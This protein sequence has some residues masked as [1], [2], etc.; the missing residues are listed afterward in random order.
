MLVFLKAFSVIFAAE[1]GDK[2][3]FL[4]IAMASKYRMRDIIIGSAGAICLLNFLA[5]ALGTLLGGLFSS[6]VV[7]I[8]SGI[9]FLCFAYSSFSESSSDGEEHAASLSK[10]AVSAVIVTFFV[11]EFGDKTQ[12]ASLALAAEESVG[13]L[14]T[15]NIIL[16]YLGATAALFVADML[17]LVVGYFL[18]K[19]IPASMFARF[20]FAIFSVV[21]IIKLIGG[22]EML[23]A[24][25]KY[26]RVFTV[27][28]SCVISIAFAA[29]CFIKYSKSKGMIRNE[30][31]TKVSKSLQIYRLK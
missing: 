10:S 30:D 15:A 22:F 11:A 16:V 26:S 29:L 1:L 6:T 19:T 24:D 4:M 17:G 3:Q 14:H 25:N 28:A 31:N 20:S 2:S 12:L 13:E 7:G 23:F 18:G 21:G 5:V 9:A 8:A 27:V